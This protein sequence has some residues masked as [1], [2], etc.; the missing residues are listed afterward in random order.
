ML[1]RPAIALGF[2]SI[3]RYLGM[4]SIGHEDRERIDRLRQAPAQKYGMVRVV[5]RK[6]RLSGIRLFKDPLIQV[7]PEA[8]LASVDVAKHQ[9]LT[10]GV[11]Y[12]E[13]WSC[14]LPWGTYTSRSV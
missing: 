13:G 10:I 14:T 11:K 9:Q 3:T 7:R 12:Q 5:D 2:D 1:R 6:K 8:R 4:I